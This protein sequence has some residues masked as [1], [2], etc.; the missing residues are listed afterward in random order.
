MF[1]VQEYYESN[2]P[3]LKDKLFDTFQ[4]LKE[5]MDTD[6]KIDYFSFW[7]GFNIP[8]HIYMDWLQLDGNKYTEYEWNM[9]QE[10]QNLVDM[11][12]PFYIIASVTD[13]WKTDEHEIAHAMYYLNI[14]YRKEVNQLI[15]E[16]S[17]HKKLY[18]FST[19]FKMGYS[20]DV[21]DDE[22][23]AWFSTSKKKELEKD[24]EIDGGS[25]KKEI[26]AFR[27]LYQKYNTITQ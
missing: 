20:K 18:I 2:K 16:M 4:F 3:N 13:D 26:K 21:Y 23:N 5:M 14:K 7:N 8:G 22:L 27:K 6:G 24:L 25:Y 17:P 1:R 12:K 19:F 15:S 9:Y 10:I 11:E